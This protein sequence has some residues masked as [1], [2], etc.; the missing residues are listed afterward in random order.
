[1]SKA[2]LITYSSPDVIAHAMSNCYHSN[3]TVNSVVHSVKA[4]H[5]SILDH[6]FATFDLEM[7]VK[8]LGQ[9]TR[10]V[11]L[12]PTVE[13]S[14]GVDLTLN[15]IYTYWEKPTYVTNEAWDRF[16]EDL[17]HQLKLSA[18]V[19]NN[20]EYEGIPLEY[21]SYTLPVGVMTKLT[22][23]ADYR[24]W[25]EY[26]PKRICKRASFEHRELAIDIYKELHRV[27]PEVFN[28]EMLGI[29]KNCDEPSCDFTSHKK[30]AKEPILLDLKKQVYNM[31]DEELRE[32]EIQ[33]EKEGGVKLPEVFVSV[34]FTGK[35][36]Y[37]YENITKKEALQLA[38]E[39]YNQSDLSD[40]EFS[41]DYIE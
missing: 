13:S 5:H 3:C 2:K 16:L 25:F 14:R 37:R 20:E 7:S 6:G 23:T 4:G 30:K 34:Y 39:E 32:E 15:G 33:E 38:Q 10:H 41:L 35:L 9:F 1:M 17:E 28:L 18:E 36:T 11:F 31:T 24:A 27:F 26:L 22:V 12:K 19:L 29:C 21:L 40:A 8:C